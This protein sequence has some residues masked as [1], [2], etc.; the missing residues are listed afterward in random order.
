MK[1]KDMKERSPEK[2]WAK[3]PSIPCVSHS[4]KVCIFTR[5]ISLTNSQEH[6]VFILI[7][8][9]DSSSSLHVEFFCKDVAVQQQSVL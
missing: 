5:L 4:N 9:D 6:F 3:S 8:A 1:I 2:R 7:Q